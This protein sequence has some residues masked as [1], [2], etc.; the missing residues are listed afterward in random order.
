MDLEADWINHD[1]KDQE[2][3]MKAAHFR[4]LRLRWS[5]SRLPLKEHPAADT[6]FK[7]YVDTFYDLRTIWY[8]VSQSQ[9]DDIITKAKAF[10]E[11]LK[12]TAKRPMADVP[13][14][15][16]P[17]K[18][19]KSESDLKAGSDENLEGMP[20]STMEDVQARTK[21]RSDTSLSKPVPASIASSS[22]LIQS[23]ASSSTL[24]SLEA[25]V[26]TILDHPKASDSAKILSPEEVIDELT[27][28]LLHG[29]IGKRKSS[30][31][32]KYL[33]FAFRCIDLI[34]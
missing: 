13:S 31:S 8:S 26:L 28:I 11:K 24:V 30:I 19:S 22:T 33:I 18:R 29:S 5:K 12:R 1:Y 21:D 7:E 10:E 14:G 6:Y 16:A 17:P 2:Q 15:Q 27:G 23:A 4:Q 32:R 34:G 25:S 3:Q 9:R 20:A